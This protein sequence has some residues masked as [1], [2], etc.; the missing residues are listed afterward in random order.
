MRTVT[1]A[2]AMQ[3]L[4]EPLQAN[5]PLADAIARLAES[6]SDG[7]PVVDERGAY[8]GTIT[9]RTI[10]QAMNDRTIEKTAGP[11]AHPTPVL[12]ES[13]PLDDA[14]DTLLRSH[15]GL[16]VAVN[17]NLT[18]WLTHLD[19]L[20]AY[21]QRLERERPATVST[22][23]QTLPLIRRSPQPSGAPASR[24]GSEQ[25]ESALS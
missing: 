8:I 24:D 21:H 1:V 17:E 4:P 19:I 9:S 2:Q 12:P 3:P 10:E 23:L 22:R 6:V 20:R 18:G 13:Q 7:L 15:S 5:T 11:L 14:L 16:P 25:S